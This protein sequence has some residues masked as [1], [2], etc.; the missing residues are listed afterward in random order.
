[1][2]HGAWGKGL[3]VKKEFTFACGSGEFAFGSVLVAG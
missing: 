1:M 2:G 3:V